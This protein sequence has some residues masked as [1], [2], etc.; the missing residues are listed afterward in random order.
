MG[1]ADRPRQSG[2]QLLKYPSHPLSW[3]GLIDYN[4]K[5]GFF[6][7]VL[8]DNTPEPKYIKHFMHDKQVVSL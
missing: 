6:S 2:G 8:D 5:I 1:V 3:G 7:W 4:K